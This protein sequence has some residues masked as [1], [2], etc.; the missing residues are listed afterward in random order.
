MNVLVKDEEHISKIFAFI[1]AGCKAEFHVAID[2]AEMTICQLRNFAKENN[3]AIE[4]YTPSRE[5]I[6]YFCASGVVAGA[7]VGYLIGAFP[8]MALGL[9]IGGISM[10]G[11]AQVKL[12]LHKPESGEGFFRLINL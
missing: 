9:A 4:I 1:K 2:I 10:Y 11:L 3:I 12:V 5:K 6:F 8:G 7:A